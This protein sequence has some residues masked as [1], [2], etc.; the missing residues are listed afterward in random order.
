MFSPTEKIP[1]FIILL[2]DQIEEQ[3]LL[4]ECKKIFGTRFKPSP[5]FPSQIN[6]SR[7][8]NR[9]RECGNIYLYIRKLSSKRGKWN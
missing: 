3:N 6:H 1:G 8:A 5:S 4:N 9:F 2:L 7:K